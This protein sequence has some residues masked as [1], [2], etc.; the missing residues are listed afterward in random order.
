MEQHLERVRV[1]FEC[2]R[3]ADL[4]LTKCKCSFLKAHVQY[5][6]H[7]ISGQGLEPVPKKL[8]ALVKMPPPEDVTGVRK[9][10]GFVGYYHKFIPRYS[11]VA[12]PL[13]N[14][15]RKDTPFRWI[16]FC[17]EA[18]EML[19]GF[20]L[21]E[22]VLKYPNPDRPYMLYTDASKYAWAGVLMQAYTHAVDGVEKRS[23][24][25]CYIRQWTIQGATSQLSH[26]GQGG[27]CYLLAT[28]KLHYYI[29][30]SDTT[31]HSDHM[32][33]HQFLLKNT[34]KRDGEQLGRG[35]RRLPTEV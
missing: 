8:E 24:P 9:F 22:P 32:P 16:T 21:E 7:Y 1:L 30:N 31:I 28:R 26:L 4:K 17:Q 13:T 14:L 23:S 15:T 12:R 5:L 3:A 29:S 6:G 27:L 34:K 35:Y 11:D 25:S 20:L 19:K 18:F 33:L 10:L 2:L